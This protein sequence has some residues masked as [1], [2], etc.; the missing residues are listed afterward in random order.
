MSGNGHIIKSRKEL[1]DY[2]DYEKF[3]LYKQIA[4]R[5]IQYSEIAKR[6]GLLALEDLIDEKKYKERDVFE[7]GLRFIV[8][9][10]DWDL[11]N[12]ILSN[13]VNQEK[14]ES[15]RLFKEIQKNAIKY[16]QEGNTHL[17]KHI[18]NSF[19]SITLKDDELFMFGYY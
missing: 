9:G 17:L 2:S 1:W 15:K 6:E 11:I 3:G 4:Y 5:A 18:I 13:I 7:C 16:I 19:S 10:T 8:D 12:K 14:N